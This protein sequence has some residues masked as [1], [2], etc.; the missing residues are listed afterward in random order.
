MQYTCR[1]RRRM[2]RSFVDI[3][4]RNP[5]RD[6]QRDVSQPSR[7]LQ[8]E[9]LPFVA[10][11]IT[12]QAKGVTRGDDLLFRDREAL[13]RAVALPLAAGPFKPS[14]EHIRKVVRAVL[15]IRQGPARGGTEEILGQQGCTA[16]IQTP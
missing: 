11:A 13:L 3:R 5:A 2:V 4:S 7:L 1:R 12:V 16:V 15:A 8:N 10:L 9:P 6:D 14:S